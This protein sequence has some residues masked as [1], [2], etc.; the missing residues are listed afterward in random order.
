MTNL[1]TST[2]LNNLKFNVLNLMTS[3]VDTN[4]MLNSI[5]SAMC[6]FKYQTE[7]VETEVFSF[8]LDRS[9]ET[10][11]EKEIEYNKWLKN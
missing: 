11:N 6:H 4:Q 7:Q 10:L 8:L 5:E 1:I 3:Y 2:N 9:R